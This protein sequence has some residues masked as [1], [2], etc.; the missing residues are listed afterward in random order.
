MLETMR[1]IEE[2]V[3]Q[4]FDTSVYVEMVISTDNR[5][6]AKIGDGDK[7]LIIDES[8]SEMSAMAYYYRRKLFLQSG[9]GEF[10]FGYKLYPSK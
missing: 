10:K 4:N 8:M 9:G 1:K 6:I 5:Y 2:V 7:T 3:H